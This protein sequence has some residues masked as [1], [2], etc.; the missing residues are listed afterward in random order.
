MSEFPT[1]RT[2]LEEAVRDTPR[3]HVFMRWFANGAWQQRTYAETLERVRILAEWFGSAGLL[4]R[5]TRVALLLPNCPHWIEVYLAVVGIAGAVVPIDPKLTAPEVHH[6]LEDSGASFIVT[7]T[8]HLPLVS[9]LA[10]TLPALQRVLLAGLAEV[11]ATPECVLP[12]ASVEAVIDAFPGDVPL[13]FWNAP[14]RIPTPDDLCGLLYTSGTT[15]KPKGAMLTHGNF[16]ADAIGALHLISEF[17][18]PQD[19]FLVVLPLFHAFAFTTNFVVALRAHSSISFLRSLRTLVEDLNTLH[20]TVL[21]TV[22]L[23]AEKLHARLMTAFRASLA[24]RLLHC[25]LPRLAG[26]RVLAALGG[27]LRLIVVGGAKADPHILRDFARMGINMVE[28]YGLTECAPVVCVNP[29][30]RNRIGT[31]GPAVGGIELRIASPDARG[32]GE[33][34]VRGAI[35]FRGYWNNASATEEA[36]T[37]DWLRTGDLATMDAEGYVTLCGRVKSLIVNREGKNIYPEEVEQAIARDPLV[38]EVVV[39]PYHT[40]GEP[41]EKVGAILSVNRDALNALHPGSTPEEVETLLRDAVKRQCRALASYKHPRKVKIS[42]DPLALTST[43]KVR[44]CLYAGTL[45]D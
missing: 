26:R 2:L 7:D 39:I 37:D 3:S 33:L 24:G 22:P 11:P 38:G 5:Q 32:V 31:I 18:T 35:T 10:P 43:H 45:D 41:G 40:H 30:R 27:K 1:L 29:P 42:L 28:G 17:V 23:M 13:R 21:M 25:A 12:C 4:P 14:T 15:G 8:A 19:D 36:Y 44:R 20:S 9:T 34:Q 6:I 16:S